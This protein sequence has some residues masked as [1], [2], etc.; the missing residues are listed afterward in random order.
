MHDVIVIGGSFAGQS[1]AMQLARARQNVSLIDAGAPRNRF[2]D[3]AHGFLGQDGRAPHA[4]MREATCQLLKYPTAEVL[5]AEVGHVVR[6]D[7]HFVLR[8]VS[9]LERQARRLILATGVSDTLP[10]IPGMAER[11][12][13]SV[14]HCPY[15]HGYE[16]RDQALGIIAN[17]PM[18]AHQAALIPDWGPAIYFT[19]GIHEPDPEQA[20]LLAKRGV[21]IERT[22]VIALLGDAPSLRAV[23]LADG[24]I[25][26]VAAVFTAPRTSQTS[27]IAEKLGCAMEEGATGPFIKVDV[28]GLTSVPGVYAAGDATSPMHNATI[29]SASGVLAGI[30]A[31]QSLVRSCH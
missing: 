9:G 15:C 20:A 30:G 18:S 8:F 4:I 16:V 5:R 31:H 2:A 1:A 22:P 11:W 17:H 29:A 12:G 24:R 21:T 25:I 26:D 23:K 10:D 13:E 19:Q 7:D 27:D 3:A 28:W 14:L 6:V